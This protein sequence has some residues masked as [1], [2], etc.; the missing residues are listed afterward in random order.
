M[1]YKTLLTVI[2][3]TVLMYACQ[4]KTKDNSTADSAITDKEM[5]ATLLVKLQNPNSYVYRSD[6]GELYR[7]YYQ[8][9]QSDQ[10]VII[11]TPEYLYLL[12]QK[13]TWAK[14]AIYQQKSISW[15]AQGDQVT[16]R[17]ASE[18]KILRQ[19]SPLVK[20]YENQ[21]RQIKITTTLE[22]NQTYVLLERKDSPNIKLEQRS[23]SNGKTTYSNDTVQWIEQDN[24]ATLISNG[25]EE[26]FEEKK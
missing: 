6:S 18:T 8:I 12:P 25:I 20:N 15:E 3:L 19:V 23:N 17:T 7:A 9:D 16:F 13:E 21:Q 1:S 11:Q 5:Q 26:Q 14:G 24:T 10:S 22:N 4:N 2:A